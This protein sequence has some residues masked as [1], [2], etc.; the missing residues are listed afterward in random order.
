[1]VKF[2]STSENYG[3]YE[4][5][6][7]HSFRNYNLKMQFKMAQWTIYCIYV[8]HTITP[9]LFPEKKKKISGIVK[10]SSKI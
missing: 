8:V 1:M 2:L 7:M 6:F 5:I 4:N 10:Y 3:L 9:P